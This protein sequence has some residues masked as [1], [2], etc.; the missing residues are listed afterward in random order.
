MSAP[1]QAIRIEETK[2]L[3]CG[4]TIN[5]VGCFDDE[6]QLPPEP[7]DLVLCIRCGAIMALADDKHSVRPL[8]EEEIEELVAD[9][10]TIQELSE[11]VARI[12]F[13]RH[14]VG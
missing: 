6:A 12:H 14:M 1:L 5:R 4:H 10:D 3:A 2:C 11:K 13:V 7:G 8:E 9:P